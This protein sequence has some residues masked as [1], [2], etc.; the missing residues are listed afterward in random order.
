MGKKIVFLLYA[1]LLVACSAPKPPA[2]RAYYFWK[3]DFRL[4]PNESRQ[5]FDTLKI[6]KLYLK[7]FDVAW[8][9]A[10]NAPSPLD[11]MQIATVLP[12]NVSVVPTIFITNETLQRI[13]STQTD[14]LAK[15]IAT[16][17]IEKTTNANLTAQVHEWQIDCD[18][19]AK[20]KNKYFA[21][22][23][24]LKTHFPNKNL[25]LSATI[26]LHQLKYP[27]KTGVPPVN[28]GMLMLYNMSDVRL[29]KTKNSILDIDMTK[30]YI[31][32][33]TKYALP[34]DIALP[35]FAWSVAF[36]GEKFEGLYNNWTEDFCAKQS[37]LQKTKQDR[38][39]CVQDTTYN[40]HYFRRGDML[41]CE[42]GKMADMHKLYTLTRHLQAADTV[43]IALFSW[44]TALYQYYTKENLNSI[45]ED[46]E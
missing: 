32:K 38:F 23:T 6:T 31:N 43:N 26:R 34:L 10:Q 28:R 2:V 25:R 29:A 8:S 37:F 16:K 44:D 7:Y 19:S 3:S 42:S 14:T 22:L 46:Y 4:S 36:K 41:R 5:L 12:K 24:A 27:K 45:F 15:H 18:W 35:C 39:T 40:M 20:T 9:A 33:N 21:V 17:I 13:D 30:Q 11:N 1:T